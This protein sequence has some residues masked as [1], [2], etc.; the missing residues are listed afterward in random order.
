M[1]TFITLSALL[2]SL[3]LSAQF[4]YNNPTSTPSSGIESNGNQAIGVHSFSVG[5]NNVS[6]GDFSTTIGGGNV[7]S[8]GYSFAAGQLSNATGVLSTA[9]GGYVMAV[10]VFLQQWDIKLQ[11]VV[12]FLLLWGV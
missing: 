8:A 1:K 2:L 6:S 7:A 5:H 9:I 11:Q 4:T 10:E 12:W 3:S